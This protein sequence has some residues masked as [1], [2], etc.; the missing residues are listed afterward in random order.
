MKLAILYASRYGSTRRA[1][2]TIAVRCR[3]AGMDASDVLTEEITRSTPVPEADTL[4]VGAPVYGGK[5][6]REVSRFLDAH[7]ERLTQ[8]RV[9]LFLSSLYA[10]TRAETQ[11]ADNVPSRLITH[12]FGC[13]Y[14]GGRIDFDS[15]SWW[16]RFIMKRIAGVEQS[17]DTTNADE[18]ERIVTDVMRG[19]PAL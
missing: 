2:E 5:I 3:E 6:P 11:L 1:A 16:D 9:G 17:V 7:L 10:G 18:L 4:L 12:S 15:L 13:Y 8:E 19:R 14:V